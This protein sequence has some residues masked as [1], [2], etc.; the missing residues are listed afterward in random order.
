MPPA[1]FRRHTQAR[2]TS[3]FDQSGRSFLLP[4]LFFRIISTPVP[5]Q[6]FHALQGCPATSRKGGVYET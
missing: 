3:L 4:S 2:L 6:A 5:S 1:V